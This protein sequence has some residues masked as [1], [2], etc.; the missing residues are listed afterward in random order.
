MIFQEKY[1]LRYILLTEQISLSDY[2]YFLRDL[3]IY[4]RF[5]Q[6]VYCIRLLSIC[7]VINFEIYLTYLIEPLLKRDSDTG[8]SL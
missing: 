5:F 4:V 2:L 1:F 8:V 6:Y 7:Y 3:P